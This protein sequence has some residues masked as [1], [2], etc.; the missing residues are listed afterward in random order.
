MDIPIS[1]SI[2]QPIIKS[3]ILYVNSL[4][5]FE[6]IQLEYNETVLGFDNKQTCFYVRERDKYGEYKPA[7]VYFYEDFAT[8]LQNG[9]HKDFYEKCKALKLDTLKTEL[10]YKFFIENEK[11]QA[12]WL[13]LL[14]TKKADWEYDTV[15]HVR[16]KLKKQFLS[17]N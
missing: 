11:T 12:V 16:Y 3:N 10:A 4:D 5:E 2:L 9:D 1:S 7:K 14:D 15:K 6:K 13:W 8:H 17:L